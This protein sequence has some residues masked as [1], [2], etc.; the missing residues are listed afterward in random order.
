MLYEL[1]SFIF[2]I[3]SSQV[4]F[5]YGSLFLTLVLSGA[6][7][8]IPEEVTILFGG[9]LAYTGVLDI[10][11]TLYV[12]LLG[13]ILGDTLGYVMGRFFGNW[14]YNKI[15]CHFRATSVLL[16]KGERYFSRYGETI[17][18]FTRPL[19]GVR[20]IIPIL[21]GHYKMK[22]S[23]FLLYDSLVTIPWTALLILLSYFLG[24]GLELITETKE[25]RHT[26]FVV[27]GLAIVCYTALQYI[28]E[29]KKETQAN[30]TK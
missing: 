4:A 16:L 19:M 8:P 3:P 15:L 13:N 26:I 17:V 27:L 25:I 22:F 20:F 14:I 11:V 24:T 1:A 7:L 29:E 6:G 9:Y 30:I 12:L 2:A 21:A 28:R 18:L 10:W 23:K 5:I